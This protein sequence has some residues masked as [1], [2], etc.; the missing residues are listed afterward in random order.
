MR[1]IATFILIGLLTLAIIY[2]PVIASDAGITTEQHEIEIAQS[3]EGLLVV[4]NI[5]VNNTGNE[6]TTSI[7]FWIQRDVS[8]IKI[9]A[10][11]SGQYLTPLPIT[12]SNI[13]EYNLSSYNLSIDPGA[14]L[15]LRLTYILSTN[16]EKFVKRITYDTSSL[17]IIFNEKELYHAEEA[18]SN[19]HISVALYRPTEAPINIT[20][21]III[22]LLVVILIASTLL[23]LRK[24][25][26]KAKSKIIESEE[27]L[28][29]KK[30]LLLTSLKDIEK[31]HRS[32][33]ISDETYN[34]LKEEYKQQAVNVMKKLEDIKK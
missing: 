28:T 19:L 17:T 14:S 25:Q 11:E 26:S 2:T 5:K 27:T 13:R 24:Q 10:V 21:L 12:S 1:R 22:F 16:T 34:K 33:N 29:I 8:D 4:E 32:K 15:D 18:Q 7:K 3:E 6:K 20:Y 23:L 31:Q 30:Q 9:L